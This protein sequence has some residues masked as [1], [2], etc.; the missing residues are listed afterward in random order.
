M[1]LIL[2]SKRKD[3]EKQN[4]PLWK[5]GTEPHLGNGELH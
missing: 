3:F 4:I 5:Q 1:F 2:E